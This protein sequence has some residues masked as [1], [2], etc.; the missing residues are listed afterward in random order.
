MKRFYIF[1]KMP[2]ILRGIVFLPESKPILKWSQNVT[3]LATISKLLLGSM[4]GS[5]LAHVEMPFL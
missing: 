4:I 2:N 5:I 3:V 1:D